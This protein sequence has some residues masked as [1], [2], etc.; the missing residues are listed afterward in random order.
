[1]WLVGTTLSLASVAGTLHATLVE[2]HTPALSEHLNPFSSLIAFPEDQDH[3]SFPRKIFRSPPRLPR[4]QAEIEPWRIEPDVVVIGNQKFFIRVW[5]GPSEKAPLEKFD[6]SP[7]R[8]K[9]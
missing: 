8:R 3:P 9:K 2:C 6:G 4:F 5:P 7:F 1:M